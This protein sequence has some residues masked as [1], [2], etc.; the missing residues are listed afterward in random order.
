MAW[1]VSEGCHLKE[2]YWK[3]ITRGGI[4]LP[5]TCDCMSCHRQDNTGAVVWRRR[6]RPP[7]SLCTDSLFRK[8]EGE[9]ITDQRPTNSLTSS[10]CLSTFKTSCVFS[11]EREMKKKTAT[12]WSADRG[13]ALHDNNRTP[14]QRGKRGGDT[15]RE[16][17]RGRLGD[18]NAARTHLK[19]YLHIL[20]TR[21]AHIWCLLVIGVYQAF[22]G[23]CWGA[24]R[25]L[26]PAQRERRCQL[27]S[28]AR[29][30]NP[31]QTNVSFCAS[32]HGCSSTLPTETHYAFLKEALKKQCIPRLFKAKKRAANF[33]IRLNLALQHQKKNQVQSMERH[34]Y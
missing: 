11:S 4:L 20:S 33:F 34:F 9:K 16:R 30:S 19:I 25:H 13:R 27:C 18:N 15:E 32:P 3:V 10:S 23:F 8:Q 12:Y 7:P 1:N 31:T 17:E 28:L 14:P 26:V 21:R 29:H 6:H 24:V 5:D 22:V 2:D